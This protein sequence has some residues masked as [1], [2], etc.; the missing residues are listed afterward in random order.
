MTPQSCLLKRNTSHKSE[1]LLFKPCKIIHK[2]T[3]LLDFIKHLLYMH[4]STAKK[5]NIIPVK[6][7][8]K[9]T[10]YRR[11]TEILFR[12]QTATF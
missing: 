11:V 9:M 1:Q 5:T 10:Q 2:K 12:Y 8:F 6:K 4:T 3:T 7:Y